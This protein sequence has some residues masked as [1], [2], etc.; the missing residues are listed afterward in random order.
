MFGVGLFELLLL[1]LLLLA[2][3]VCVVLVVRALTR[4]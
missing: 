2:G 3:V 1:A 4:H